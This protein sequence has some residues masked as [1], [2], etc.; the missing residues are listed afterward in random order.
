MDYENIKRSSSIRT[1]YIDSSM[2]L[3][4]LIGA[5]DKLD[6]IIICN[7]DRLR[8][9]TNDQDI[10]HALGSVKEY[11]SFRLNKLA[12]FFEVVS[13]RTVAKKE[14]LTDDIVGKLRAAALKN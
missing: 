14:L 12:K 7:P 10:Y 2:L 11:D 9:V 5:D 3:K 6:T 8:F 13:I 4:Y 1:F